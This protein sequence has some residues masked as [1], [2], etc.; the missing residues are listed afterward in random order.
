MELGC[1][2]RVGRVHSKLFARESEMKT[3]SP[4]PRSLMD[5]QM[6]MPSRVRAV[7]EDGR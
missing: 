1:H 4:L 6:L 7:M 2:L 5:M 3:H